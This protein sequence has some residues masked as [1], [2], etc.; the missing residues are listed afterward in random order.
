MNVRLVCVDLLERNNSS[1]LCV[2]GSKK[3]PLKHSVTFFFLWNLRN[4]A[5]AA[6]SLEEMCKY[7]F[8]SFW[9][10]NCWCFFQDEKEKSAWNSSDFDRDAPYLYVYVKIYVRGINLYFPK[11]VLL[12]CLADRMQRNAAGSAAICTREKQEKWK[13]VEVT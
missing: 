6:I 11:L 3:V 12:G 9:I 2:L 13:S 10:K 5:N 8:T 4:L 1:I 7:K